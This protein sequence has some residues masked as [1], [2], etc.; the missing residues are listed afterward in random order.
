MSKHKVFISY[1]HAKDQNYKDELVEKGMDSDIFVD[2]SVDTGDIDD[3]LSDERIREII[4]DDYLK[5]SSVT[6]ILVG[7]ETKERKHVDWEIY[8]SMYDGKVNKKSGILVINLPTAK[9]PVR[10]HGDDEKET[11]CPDC[12]WTSYESHRER[13]PKTPLRL[14]DNFD[15]KVPIA[16][17]NYDTII[18]D[19]DA[20]ELLIDN[21]YERRTTNDYN[22][23]RKMK[24]SNYGD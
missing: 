14:I 18:D 3:S 24:R 19:M 12:T 21:A 1:H 16:V 9:Q 11:V 7:E 20:L 23:T 8:S 4:R 17:V 6:I 22:L 2:K 13:Y 10:A 5:D 15:D